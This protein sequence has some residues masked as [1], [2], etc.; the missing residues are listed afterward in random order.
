MNVFHYVLIAVSI[1]SF[2]INLH[3]H[4]QPKNEK[5]QRYNAVTSFYSLAIMIIL[6]IGSALIK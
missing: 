3:K 5:D 1:L 4:G 6:V 2:M